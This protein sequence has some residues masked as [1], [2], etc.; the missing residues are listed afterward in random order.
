MR[1]VALPRRRLLRYRKAGNR[2][3]KYVRVPH[4]WRIGQRVLERWINF[5]RWSDIFRAVINLHSSLV[6]IQYFGENNTGKKYM[7]LASSDY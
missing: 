6:T 4:V 1:T 7:N 2:A 5:Y 3:L